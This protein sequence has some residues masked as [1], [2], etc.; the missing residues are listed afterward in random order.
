MSAHMRSL[1]I[2]FVLGRL[3]KKH[4]GPLAWI[5][6]GTNLAFGLL[7]IRWLANQRLPSTVPSRLLA[8]DP[9]ASR[10]F[11]TFLPEEAPQG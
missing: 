3:V 11:A 7:V 5:V 10:L 6:I 1:L 9:E 2:A 8:K 4:S